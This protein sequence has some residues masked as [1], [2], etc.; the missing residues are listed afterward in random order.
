MIFSRLSASV[1]GAMLGLSVHHPAAAQSL[2]DVA[3]LLQNRLLPQNAAPDRRDEARDAY[4]QGRADAYREQNARG[5]ERRVDERRA[6][7]RRRYED[8]RRRGEDDRQ[9]RYQDDRR[10]QEDMARA[11]ADEDRARRESGRY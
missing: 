3:N 2:N 9:R 4:N 5:D 11:R 6:E 10:H 7:D 1:L 8:E